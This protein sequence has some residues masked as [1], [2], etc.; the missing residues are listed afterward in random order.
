ME[1]LTVVCL[2]NLMQ[3]YRAVRCSFISQ[4]L[5]CRVIYKCIRD[6]IISTEM[7]SD[8][9]CPI[10]AKFGVNVESS[11]IVNKFVLNFRLLFEFR[12]YYVFFCLIA[13][14]HV[15]CRGGSKG[16][17]APRPPVRFLAPLWP[18]Q[19]FK[20]RPPLAKISC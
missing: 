11:A 5:H 15:T 1:S 9:L 6:F 4:H 3:I 2:F 13:I 8:Y 16:P 14:F 10:P 20:I 19:K 18:P 12:N 17:G 7:I